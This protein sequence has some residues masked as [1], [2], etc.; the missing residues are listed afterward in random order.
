MDILFSE[1]KKK[2]II[3]VST[4]KKLGKAA[5][6][7]FIF[8]EGK[9]KS[10]TVTCGFMGMGESKTFSFKE[11][12]RVGEDAILVNAKRKEPPCPPPDREHEHGAP[13]R[14]PLPPNDDNCV[15]LRQRGA[16]ELR[17]DL[18]DYE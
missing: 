14:P 4:G 6:I 7:T 12:E 11:I 5:D 3:D 1:F 13:C 9:V 18:D 15:P 17:L 8:P 10:V 2:D 16:E